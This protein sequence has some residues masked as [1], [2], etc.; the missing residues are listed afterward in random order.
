[1]A[2]EPAW[3]RSGTLLEGIRLWQSRKQ[4]LTREDVID[5]AMRVLRLLLAIGTLHVRTH[6]DVSD[7]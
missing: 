3:N 7:P 2:G 1:M 5:R 6:A 4:R